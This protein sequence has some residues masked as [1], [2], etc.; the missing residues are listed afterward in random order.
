MSA[1]VFPAGD[2]I[3]L[4][5]NE[6][7]DRT[8]SARPL[9][10]AFTL[11]VDGAEVFVEIGFPLSFPNRLILI[12]RNRIN[13]GQSVLLSYAD[14]TTGDDAQA[15]QD[16]AGNDAAGFT[17]RT[18]TNNST[19]KLITSVLRTTPRGPTSIWL[20]WDLLD[21]VSSEDITSYILEASDDGGRTWAELV[22]YTGDRT[23]LRYTMHRGLEPLTTYSYRITP[24]TGQDTDTP[25]AIV[26][27]TTEAQPAVINGLS[28][29]VEANYGSHRAK[30][31]LC[32]TP[33]GEDIATLS[34][35]A[36]GVMFYELD[37][38][39]AL[40]WEDD[41]TFRFSGF[42]SSEC[43]DGAGVGI[44]RSYL[45]G[46]KYFVKFRAQRNGRWVESNTVTVQVHNPRTTLK[47]RIMAE[48]FY[49]IGPDGEPVFPD[50]PKTVTGPFEI[51][52]G[53]GYHFP[54]DASTTE[55]TGLE[56]SD[57]V[58]T[59]ATV[60]APTEDGFTFEQFIGYRVVVTPTT[61]GQDVTV[62]VKANAVTG[63]GTTK[64][65]RASN[66]LRRKTAP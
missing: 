9:R 34:E 65:N 55:V 27:A 20:E 28:W 61:L 45:S 15:V 43:A 36:Y 14:P 22:D 54:I 44:S 66:V 57:F 39:S 59:N 64:T 16:L 47:A 60:S 26:R 5:Y 10:S 7:L 56:V 37:E 62:R 31:E 32:W 23:S 52:V 13:Q 11:T 1:H 50:V 12:P 33:D 58:V 53:F 46:L 18:V 41:G 35:F 4:D 48:G 8:L 24:I 6:D 51:A 21:N 38:Y 17:D 42:T 2:V 19:R 49:G 63:Q 25:S 29:E 40:P 30:A 3:G